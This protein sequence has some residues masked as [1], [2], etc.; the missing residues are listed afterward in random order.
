MTSIDIDAIAD[1]V[2]PADATDPE[3]VADAANLLAELLRRL[4]RAT[5]HPESVA[6]PADADQVV[7]ALTIAADRLPQLCNQLAARMGKIGQLSGLAAD[8]L[9]SISDPATIAEAAKFC[10]R[11]AADKFA[12]AARGLRAA[13]QHTSRLYIDG[14]ATPVVEPPLPPQ[15]KLQG[16]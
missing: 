13:G 10:T 1:Q 5:R 8:N 15:P 16:P 3:Q 12:N 11:L 2:L 4:C 9:G 7:A 14:A 6:T